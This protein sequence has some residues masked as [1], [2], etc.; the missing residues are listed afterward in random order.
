VSTILKFNLV[1]AGLFLVLLAIVFL[2]IFGWPASAQTSTRSFYD[3]NGSFAGQSFQHE[4]STSFSDRNGLYAG[5]SIRNSDGTTS[6]YDRSGHF[7][8][9]SIAT[10]REPRR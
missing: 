7:T 4:R 3:S 6:F 10:S 1:L 2:I 5:S 9:S 8:G